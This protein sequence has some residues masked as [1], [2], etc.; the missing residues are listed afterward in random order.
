MPLKLSAAQ[1][2]WLS[3]TS[4]PESTP[5]PPH[6]M[7]PYL[8]ATR[9]Q[10]LHKLVP[11]FAM[12]TST[13]KTAPELEQPHINAPSSVQAVGAAPLM[14]LHLEHALDVLQHV[15]HETHV[16]PLPADEKAQIQ[17]LETLQETHARRHQRLAQAHERF[18][19][20]LSLRRSSRHQGLSDEQ[21]PISWD[22]WLDDSTLHAYAIGKLDPAEH[23]KPDRRMDPHQQHLRRWLRLHAKRRRKT[24]AH[25]R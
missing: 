13:T 8:Q 2:D 16:P 6:W 12:S 7:A 5:I 1:N 4:S 25:K 23:D 3:S 24:L 18:V 14:T 15:S 19:I 11:M 21:T 22:A 9:L 17:L 10:T 20:P